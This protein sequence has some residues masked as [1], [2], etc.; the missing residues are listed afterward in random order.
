MRFLAIRGVKSHC[1]LGATLTL[2]QRKL[3][4]YVASGMTGKAAAIASG[5]SHASATSTASDLLNHNLPVQAYLY[6][7][8]DQKGLTDSHLLT[9]LKE[10]LQA[11]KM[12]G[13]WPG[14]DDRTLP[15]AKET[16]GD[17]VGVPD[18]ATRHKYLETGLKLRGH[19][20]PEMKPDAPA[21][22]INILSV[23]GLTKEKIFE[24][25]RASLGHR[26]AT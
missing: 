25:L 20:Q 12:V 17:Y 23:D 24:R 22:N 16:Q 21:V 10:G 11:K 1:M 7:L 18:Y 26:R 9:T 14:K 5:Y 19:L 4:K 13:L 15:D 6:R 2:K 3:A 8:M